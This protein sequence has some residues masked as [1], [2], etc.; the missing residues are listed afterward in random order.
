MLECLSSR[1]TK[2]TSFQRFNNFQVPVTYT[3]ININSLLQKYFL[4]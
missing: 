3:T 2:K 1:L 4:S